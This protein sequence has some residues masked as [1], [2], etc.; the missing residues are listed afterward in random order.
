MKINEVL[1][2]VDKDVSKLELDDQNK[3]KLFWKDVI[4]DK[5]KQHFETNVDGRNVKGYVDSEKNVLYVWD[6][7]LNDFVVA[8]PNLVRRIFGKNLSSRIKKLLNFQKGFVQRWHD[9]WDTQNPS[10]PGAGQAAKLGDAPF[11]QQKLGTIGARA[12]GIID[13]W[14]AKRKA[15]KQLGDVWQQT[16]GVKAPKP[17][18]EIVFKTRDGKVRSA[19]VQMLAINVDRDGDGVPDV[20][21]KGNVDPANPNNLTTFTIPSS[22]VLSIRGQELKPQKD[23]QKYSTDPADLGGTPQQGDPAD[24]GGTPQ[25]GDPA[26]V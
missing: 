10:A 12:G 17:G 16:Y 5:T 22:N 6:E 18:D 13:K 2:E 3:K 11:F 14:R 21:I 9:W 8:D 1:A 24:L 20:V 26:A 4:K 23:G 19:V 7:G 25:Q 15:Q